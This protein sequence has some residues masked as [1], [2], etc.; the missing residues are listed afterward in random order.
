MRRINSYDFDGV[1]YIPGFKGLIPRKE[2]IIVSGR[3]SDE[4]PFVEGILQSLEIQVEC[5]YLQKLELKSRTRATS[6]FHK[7]S[8][9]N[10]LGPDRIGL[11]F[12]DDQLQADIIKSICPW[13]NVVM[14]VHNLTEK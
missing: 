1:I 14:I 10:A 8:I 2:D 7:A 3:V 4:R 6:G 11:H 9:L 12:E 13:L 5:I